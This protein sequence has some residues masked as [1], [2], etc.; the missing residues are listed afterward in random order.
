MQDCIF[1]RIIT[2]EVP[3]DKVYED[4]K[5]LA[6]L[7]IAPINPGHTLLVPKKHY[8]DIISAPDEVLCEIMKLARLLGASVMKGLEAPAF[9]LGVNTGKEAGQAVFHLH[10]HVIPRFENDGHKM[11]GGGSYRGG[12]AGR[13][14]EK[15]KKEMTRK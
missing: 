3:A 1:C 13:V 8:Q 7:D 9:N 11:W 14:A 2:G 15:I 12:E 4:D 6:F 10:L 5:Y